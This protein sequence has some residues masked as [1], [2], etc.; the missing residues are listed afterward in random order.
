MAIS[1]KQSLWADTP[2]KLIS[3][4]GALQRSDIPPNHVSRFYATQMSLIHNGILR[5]FNSA[6]NQ[7][8][9]VSLADTPSFLT[10]LQ[11]I[12]EQ[13]HKHHSVEEETMFPLIE[14]LAGKPGIM[15][16]NIE[17]H[18]AFESGLLVYKAYVFDTKPE[19]FSPQELRRILDSFCYILSEHLHEEIPTLLDLHIYDSDALMKIWKTTEKAALSQLDNYRHGPLMFGCQDLSFRLDGKVAP[20]FPNVPFFVPYLVRFLYER[21]H[22]DVWKFNPC[23]SFRARRELPI[24]GGKA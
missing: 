21:T 15:D 3:E 4:T 19:D 13:L 22:R 17:Q 16:G 24:L 23:S 6:Y 1:E 10:Y 5:A 9:Y 8:P 12:Y 11:I 18:H 7:A 2:F 20:A 14:Q